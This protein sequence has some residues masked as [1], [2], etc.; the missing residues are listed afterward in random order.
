MK[1]SWIFSRKE[2]NLIGMGILSDLKKKWWL[3]P[4]VSIQA[5][6][7]AISLSQH[8]KKKGSLKNWGQWLHVYSFAS[9]T[10][11]V[12]QPCNFVIG[13][14]IPG[15]FR[16]ASMLFSW[17]QFGND[18]SPLISYLPYNSGTP[19]VDL[20]TMWKINKYYKPGMEVVVW[21]ARRPSQNSHLLNI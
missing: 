5:V 12:A 6:P 7:F 9:S 13:K 10:K 19:L 20:V 17:Q 15:D 4:Y 11:M 1:P 8:R 14:L 2:R 18:S 3:G 16:Q 21:K